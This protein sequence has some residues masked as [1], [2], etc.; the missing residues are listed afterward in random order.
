MGLVELFLP[1]YNSLSGK[2]LEILWWNDFFILGGIVLIVVYYQLSLSGAYPAFY[3]SGFR[4][5]EAIKKV[6]S[7]N[8][9]GKWNSL[10]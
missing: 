5:V 6:R 7:S 8:R 2:N 10:R 4:P 3:L 9:S 1:A